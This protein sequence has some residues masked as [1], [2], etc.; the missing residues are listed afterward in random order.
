MTHG[1][2]ESSELENLPFDKDTKDCELTKDIIYDVKVEALNMFND[3]ALASKSPANN[4]T[5]N[6]SYRKEVIK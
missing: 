5:I 4:N 1:K 6:R 2:E 3:T